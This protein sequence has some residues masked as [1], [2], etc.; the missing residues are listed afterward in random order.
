[1]QNEAEFQEADRIHSP[2]RLYNCMIRT[3]SD[4]LIQVFPHNEHKK[5]ERLVELKK[6]KLESIEQRKNINVKTLLVKDEL[7]DMKPLFLKCVL[8]QWRNNLMLFRVDKDL[9][10]ECA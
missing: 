2:S 9:K 4:S 6:S 8:L 10:K 1:M 3:M 5:D 7:R